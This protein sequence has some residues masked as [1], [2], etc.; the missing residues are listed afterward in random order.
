MGQ[1]QREGRAG[2]RR[3][4]R[5]G[6]GRAGTV[7]APCLALSCRLPSPVLPGHPAPA[8]SGA[9]RPLL[10]WTPSP[11]A[12]DSGRQS[13][14]RARLWAADWPPRPRG[15]LWRA[16]RDGP[17]EPEGRRAPGEARGEHRVPGSLPAEQ[18][19]LSSRHV[20]RQCVTKGSKGTPGPE[21]L[22]FC[23]PPE[24]STRFILSQNDL[25]TQ[26]N[27][28]ALALPLSAQSSSKNR[29]VNDFDTVQ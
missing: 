29:H 20:C 13:A 22:P 25:G 16:G 17:L 3:A 26:L 6:T 23:E 21:D 24:P 18:L 2:P 9:A 10:A 11:G 8:P 5:E 7:A 1:W 15:A 19:R 12:G 27:L 28:S 14:R 4:P